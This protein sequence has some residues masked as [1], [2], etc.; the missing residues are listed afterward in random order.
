MYNELASTLQS[1]LDP[2]VET[3]LLALLKMAGFTKK[4]TAQCSQATVTILLTYTTPS[5]R[6]VINALSNGLQDKTPQARGYVADHLAKY[7]DLH[8]GRI[9]PAVIL[10]VCWTCLTA[11]CE[12]QLQTRTPLPARQVES[13][14]GRLKAFG[15]IARW[16]S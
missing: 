12:R 2:V 9:K 15:Q 16:R 10:G 11:R 7:L 13:R 3:M 8:G 4:I 5:P 14:T 1:D 6:I